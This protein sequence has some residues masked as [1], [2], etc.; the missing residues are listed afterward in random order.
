MLAALHEVGLAPDLV[1]GTSAGALN[2][3]A[4]AAFGME[5]GSALLKVLWRA[6][7]RH[8][9]FPGNRLRQMQQRL[10]S[11]MSLFSNESLEAL[12]HALLPAPTFAGMRLPL[13]VMVTDLLTHQGRL[14]TTGELT[15]ALLASAALPGL[16]P[17]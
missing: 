14:I 11:R 5:D 13:G 10:S 17:P 16:Y 4:I 1:T 9:L 2:G 3:A 8:H 6:L 12:I 15:P 7:K